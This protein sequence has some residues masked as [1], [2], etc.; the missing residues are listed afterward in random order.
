MDTQQI[1]TLMDAMS[2]SDLTDLEFSQDGWTLRLS[3]K[4]PAADASTKASPPAPAVASATPAPAARPGDARQPATVGSR[5]ASGTLH[6]P[7]YGLVHL[8]PSPTEPPFA[9]VGDAVRAG[10]PLCVIEAMKVFNEVRAE[11]DGVLQEICVTSG[12]EVDSGQVLFRFA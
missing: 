7:L 8:S 6:A 2:A 12:Q 10:Q 9:G 1:K 5:A 3:R 4:Q 11:H